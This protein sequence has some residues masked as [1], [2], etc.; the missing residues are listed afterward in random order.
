M[1]D[2]ITFVTTDVTHPIQ[3][4]LDFKASTACW[5]KVWGT[6]HMSYMYTNISICLAWPYASAIW[7]YVPFC[8]NSLPKFR[9]YQRSFTMECQSDFHASFQWQKMILSTVQTKC[10]G[11]IYFPQ[12][13]SWDIGE[14]TAVS[15]LRG[16]GKVFWP[17]QIFT[18]GARTILRHWKDVWK[19]LW[20]AP[21]STLSAIQR[22]HGIWA[23]EQ[24]SGLL[25][26]T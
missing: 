7:F 16:C 13:L 24:L 15:Q 17:E 5:N 14:N 21:M 18:L 19:S 22:N 11:Q 10:S 4:Y 1:C 2:I 8:A 20:H 26:V 23:T 25:I 12:S 9:H 3:C 6:R